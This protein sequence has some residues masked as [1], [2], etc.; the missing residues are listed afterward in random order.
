MANVTGNQSPIIKAQVYSEFMLEQLHAGFLPDNLYRNVSDF[1]DGDTLYV[2]VLGETIIRDYAEDTGVVFD[3]I[4]TG[5]VT[6]TISDYVSGASYVTDKLKEDAYKAAFLEA[7]IPR[8][9]LRLI[10]ERF[11]S[12]LLNQVNKQTAADP[13]SINGFNHRWVASSG[14][15][16]GVLTLDDLMYAKLALDEVN[17][18][19][20]GRLFIVPPICETSI[21]KQVGAQAYVNN[22]QFEGIVTTGMAKSM[23][24]VRNIFGFDIW[25]STR[26]PLKATSEQINGWSGNDTLATSRVCT[27]GVFGNDMHTPIMGAWRQTPKTEG[28]RNVTFKRDEY[29]TTAR[30]GLGLQRRDTIGAV[31]VS[32]SVFQ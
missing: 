26:C 24:F 9:H 6:L 23:K 5:Q 25:V 13:N 12:D 30:W 2:P 7:A 10:K 28:D 17:A 15:T 4:D 11:E 29:S 22:P 3:A 19:E 1:G 14:T 21:N 18:P 16:N 20:E 32:P 31:L 8:E 27:F